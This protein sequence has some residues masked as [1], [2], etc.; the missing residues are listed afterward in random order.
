MT[1]EADPVAELAALG[2]ATDLSPA[3]RQRL[4]AIARIEELPAGR[5]VLREGQPTL[6]LGVVLDGRVALQTHLSGRADLTLMTLDRGDIFGWSAA[7]GDPSTSSVVA[8]VPTRAVLLERDGLLDALAAD[9][10]FAAAIYRR[11]FQ[12]VTSRLVATRLQLL[13]LYASAEGRA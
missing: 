7:L 11:L 8:Q 5:T 13:D 12:A 6:E 10:E 4:A 9:P 1:L 3:A 2:I